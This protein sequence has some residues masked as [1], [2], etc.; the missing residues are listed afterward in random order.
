MREDTSSL[1]S[2]RIPNQQRWRMSYLKLRL[3]LFWCN[4]EMQKKNPKLSFS[5]LPLFP[6][7]HLVHPLELVLLATTRLIPFSHLRRVRL[8]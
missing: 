7:S 3:R 6:Q 8:V 5:T 2:Q 4:I 1:R